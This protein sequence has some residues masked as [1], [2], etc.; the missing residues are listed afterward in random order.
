MTKAFRW[1]FGG[2]ISIIVITAVILGFIYYFAT[3][4]IPEYDATHVRPE[5]TQA[6]EIVRDSHA[7]P[8]IFGET[9]ADVMYG[10]GFAHAQDRLWQME[11]MRRTAQGRLSEMFGPRTL[12]TDELMRALDIYGLSRNAVANQTP[13]TLALLLAYSAG[14]NAWVD[15]TRTQALGRGA[16][17]FF[18]YSGAIAEWRPADSIALLKLMA[19][20]L[21]DKAA[22]EVLR[23]KLSFRVPDARIRDILPDSP[24]AISMPLPE[25]SALFPDLGFSYAAANIADMTPLQ[26]VGFAGASNAWAALGSRSASGSTLMATDPHLALTAPGIWM[27]ARLELQ[28]GGVIGATIPGIP[29]VLIGRNADL[30]WGLTASYLDDQ[31]LYLE[32]LNP[33]NS[34]EYLTE[35]GAIA[36]IT[37]PT[38]IEI[39]GEAS[40]TRTLRWTD[41]GPIIPGDHF[42]IA[43]LRSAGHEISL[44]W[45]ALTDQDQTIKAVMDLMNA[46]S[47]AEGRMAISIVVAPSNNVILADRNSVAMVATGLVPRRDPAHETQGRIPSQGWLEVNTWRGFY[48][49]NENPMVE[50]PASGIVVNTNNAISNAPF[51]NH[52]SF[53]WGDT[54]RIQRATA[55][56]NNRQFH[57]KSSFI[58][59]Q[60]DIVSPSARILLPLIG[61]DLWFA[62]QNAEPNSHGARR[63]EALGLLASWNGEMGQHD[64]EPLIYAAWVRALQGRLIWDEL[65][66]MSAEITAVNPLFLERVFRNIDGASV[67]CDVTPTAEI[68]TCKQIASIALDDALQ[69]LVKKNGRNINRW[70]WGNAHKAFHENEVLGRVPVAA[71]IANIWQETSGGDNTLMRGSTR[72]TGTE[73]FTNVHASGFRAVYDF[74]DLDNS[75]FIT[76]TGQSG[77]FLSRHYDDLSVIWR[78]GEY[79][80]MSLDPALARG[81]AV[82]ITRLIPAQ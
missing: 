76:A 42:G 63:R 57:T 61:A 68:E 49:F 18:L 38:L 8:H 71:W 14:V 2:F 77:H 1:I 5:L 47:V 67:W 50:N 41:H 69:G 58:A 79:I 52:F 25:F 23:A 56:L 22:M 28:S 30:G 36:F 24:E 7:I 51:P 20:Q 48:P 62:D 46:R 31:D 4:S 44:S 35:D 37:R 74:D 64:P 53:D 15:V 19:L 21:T 9:D 16:P 27:L 3:R 17:E 60:S 40:V 66:Q 6:V 70:R 73:P 45:T 39:K 54:Q 32:R 82:G 55:L 29:A 13:E 33:Q 10:L 65:G 59:M 78:R 75:V 26:P 81:G 11:M 34:N 12:A 43:D 80:P 72:G